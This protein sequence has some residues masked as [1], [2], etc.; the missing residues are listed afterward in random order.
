MKRA[1]KSGDAVLVA[2]AENEQRDA[3][4][5]KDALEK[6]KKDL[7]TYARFYEFI[8]QIVDFDDTALEKLNLYARHLYP[9]LRE[10]EDEDAPDLT[11]VQLT[12]YRLQKQREQELML[13][14]ANSLKPSR[15]P[16]S[17]AAT[18]TTN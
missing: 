11:N 9:L 4:G 14:D 1:K 5:R 17:P 16:C 2:N 8:S 6:F 3:K 15:R 7:G 10:E 12:H 18:R 13:N